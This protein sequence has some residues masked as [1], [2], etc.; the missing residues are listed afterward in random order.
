M[1]KL[2]YLTNASI[3]MKKRLFTFNVILCFIFF[4]N[5][6]FSQIDSLVAGVKTVVIDPGHG[7][8]DPGCHGHGAKEKDVAL[9]IGLTLGKYIEETYP[10]IKVIYTR[11]TDVF[12]ELDERANIA[13]KNNADLFIC[14]HANAGPEAAR[15][16]E[17]YVLGLHRTESQK[18]IADRENSAIHFEDNSEEKYKDFEMTPDAIIARTFQLSVYLNNS[19]SFATKIQNEFA[20]LGR[21]NRGVK[22]AGFLVL[23]KTTMPAVLIETGF[24]SNKEEALFLASKDKQ[25]KMAASIFNAFQDY[26]KEV[27]FIDHGH[28]E[29][30]SQN[31]VEIDDNSIIFRVQIATS[32]EA[33]TNPNTSLG[34]DNLFIYQDGGLHKYTTGVFT[35]FNK[36][37]AVKQEIRDKGQFPNA[38]VVAFKGKERINLQKAIKLA[39]N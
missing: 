24:L 21:H 2:I 25:K 3:N 32:P 19:I 16:A 27:E 31:N 28:S 11:S 35:D 29:N 12:V 22:Q 17:T 1:A 14:I 4:T 10:E 20:N 5:P 6:V 8:K 37:N 18:R 39:E 38:F 26:K 36:A 30:S 15:G 7:G 34:V 23:Y 13:N 9:A 33:L